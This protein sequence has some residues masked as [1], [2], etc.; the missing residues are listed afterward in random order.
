MAEKPIKIFTNLAERYPESETPDKVL[1]ASRA[2]LAAIPIIG[3]PLTEVLSMILAPPVSNRRDEWFREL[4]DGLG[5][6]E[7]KFEEFKLENLQNN[8]RFISSVIQATQA[9]I[10]T[11]HPDKRAMLRTAL[12]NSALG[13]V[14]KEELEEAF[15]AAVNAL[16]P[17]HIKILNFYWKGLELLMAAGLWNQLNP[18]ALGNYATAIGALYPDMKGR[19]DFLSYLMTDLRNRGFATIARPG[20]AFPQSPGITGMG[21]AF[22][23]FILEPPL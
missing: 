16:S 4:A 11:H 5:Q 18:Y 8:E 2:L 1:G 17:S 3:S 13:R 19:D 7:G 9:A 21:V 10:A 22:L 12:L 20:D 6:L 14:P 15:I 23:R